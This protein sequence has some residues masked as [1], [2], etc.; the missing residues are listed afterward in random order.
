VPDISSSDFF[1][2][3]PP[4]PPE[5]GRDES[6]HSS[7]ANTFADLS[8]DLEKE[9]PTHFSLFPLVDSPEASENQ[10]MILTVEGQPSSLVV[11]VPTE[12]S[13]LVEEYRRKIHET[14]DDVVLRDKIEPNPPVRG[15]VGW[16]EIKIKPGFTP[17]KARPIVL[18][19]ERRLGMEGLVK[20]WL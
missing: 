10:P 19:G 18:H 13:E 12:L 5:K 8:E 17:Q 11:E 2:S 15:P 16:A 20:E 6:L 4:G 14:Y 7:L 1:L 3:I 9:D